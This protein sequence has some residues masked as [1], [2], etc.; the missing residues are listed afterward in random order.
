MVLVRLG[1]AG[2]HRYLLNS[3][4]NLTQIII[5][6]S[7][8]VLGKNGLSFEILGVLAKLSFEENVEKKKS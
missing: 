1:C 4:I 7:H 3:H 5:C 6:L 8:G 2:Y